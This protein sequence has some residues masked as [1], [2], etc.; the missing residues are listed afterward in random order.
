MSKPLRFCAQEALRRL[1]EELD[2]DEGKSYISNRDSYFNLFYTSEI[3]QI[4]QLK[5]MMKKMTKRAMLIL[6]SLNVLNRTL[7]LIMS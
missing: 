3:F 4:I 5:M 2:D 1:H 7:T 6:K